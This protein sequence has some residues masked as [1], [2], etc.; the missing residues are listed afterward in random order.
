MKKIR[1][2]IIATVII[3]LIVFL[4]TKFLSYR[5]AKK[6]LEYI[7]LESDYINKTPLDR[8]I[9]KSDI[10]NDSL[11]VY[12]FGD[13][14]II[15]P[16][17]DTLTLRRTNNISILIEFDN[18]SKLTIIRDTSIF[19]LLEILNNNISYDNLVL[20]K[21]LQKNGIKTNYDF[22]NFVFNKTSADLNFFKSKNEVILEAAYL[23]LKTINQIRGC[24][25]AWYKFNLNHIKGFQYCEPKQ[26]SETFIQFFSPTN[27]EFMII[28]DGITQEEIDNTLLSINKY[29]ENISDLN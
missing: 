10:K 11:P 26:C 14:E 29:Y 2:T 12:K 9:S 19:N 27:E 22:L 15:I 3:L 24:E 21:D 13:L 25:K 7:E 16:K 18:N 23:K 4:T 20:N 6:I 1:F 28:T 17:K 5:E 8:N